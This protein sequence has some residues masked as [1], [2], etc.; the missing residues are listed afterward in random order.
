[1]RQ[2]CALYVKPRTEK[3]FAA[4]LA[5]FHIWHILIL[6]DNVRKIQRRIRHF[7]IPVFPGYVFA[8]LGPDE[9]L[10]ALKSNMVV[11]NIPVPNPRQMIHQLRQVV[12]ADRKGRDLKETPIFKEGQFVKIK[13]GPLHG[14]EGYVKRDNGRQM[15][16]LNVEVLGQAVEIQ[17]NPEDCVPGGEEAEKKAS[18]RR[19]EGKGT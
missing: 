16:V 10:T 11:R 7:Q 18:A 8:K 15:L 1:M 19:K 17:I 12:H 2:W 9:R 13:Y 14:M 5:I 3:K 6:R 4:Y